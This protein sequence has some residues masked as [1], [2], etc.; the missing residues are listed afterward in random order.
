MVVNMKK[1]VAIY[2]GTFNPFHIGH[3]DIA[4]QAKR[5]FDYTLVA[6]GINPEKTTETTS[7][8]PTEALL[9]NGIQTTVFGCLLSDFIIKAE[10]DGYDVVLIRGLRSG[11]DLEYEQ[12]FAAFLKGMKSDV[13]IVAFYCIPEFR[14]I[15]SRA[16][17]GI[18]KFSE[19]EYDKY[20]VK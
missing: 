13:K 19:A 7:E 18:R 4:L 15:S 6:K 10:F 5:I 17:R 11:S 20:V 9:R 16:L 2:A 3:F 14:H 12:N 1:Q 8:L